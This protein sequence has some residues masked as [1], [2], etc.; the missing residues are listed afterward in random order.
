MADPRAPTQLLPPKADVETATTVRTP[1]QLLPEPASEQ[2]IKVSPGATAL[3]EAVGAPRYEAL[4]LLGT[5]GMGEIQLCLDVRI[6]R[7]VARKMMHPQTRDLP[8]GQQRFV[9][10]ARVQGQLEHPVVVPV[11]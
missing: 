5:G 1:G 7:E 8:D 6:G 9:R 2:R 10:E 4:K 3:H 11:Y